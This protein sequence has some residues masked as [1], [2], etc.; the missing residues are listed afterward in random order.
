M[1]RNRAVVFLSTPLT[2]VDGALC[3]SE[4]AHILTLGLLSERFSDVA[5]VARCRN[6]AV[7]ASAE[8]V[9]LEQTGARLAYQLPDFGRGL[10]PLMSAA[11]L[12]LSPVRLRALADLVAP[13]DIL[14]AEMPSLEGMLVWRLAR[15]HRKPYVIEMRG[16]G[17]LNPDYLRA[18]VGRLSSVLGPMI[19]K[20]FD[21]ARRG[22]VGGLFVGELLRERYAPKGAV[23][24]VAS[25][26]RLPPGSPRAP[27]AFTSSATRFLFVGHL[28]KI[29]SVHF[30][31]A[32][33]AQ[34]SPDLPPEW[35][36]DIVGDGPERAALTLLAQEAGIGGHVRFHGRV[37]WGDELFSF[38]QR[39]DLLLMASLTEGNSRTLLE[40]MAF[41]LPAVSTAVGEASRHLS[42]A[43]L[44][45]PGARQAFADT[46]R[47]IALSP[48]SLRELSAHN[49]RQVA[50]Y[51]PDALR[52]RRA[53]FLD[54]VL[55]LPRVKWHRGENGGWQ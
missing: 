53:L 42:A 14:Y 37:P 34:L 20:G 22:A 2:P 11:A 23:T 40:G 16:E 5:V 27:R 55:A 29:K 10:R 24:A 26:V 17:P 51:A 8:H 25:S 7:L 36:L 32:A 1:L 33:L 35:R 43:A 13:A 50:G 15:R 28:E 52:E 12:F 47:R 39:A 54:T 18:R 9:T 21:I 30:I 3:L 41:A 19:A 46:V 4:R 38:Y 44:A 45:P 49:A 6:D 31:I 48:A